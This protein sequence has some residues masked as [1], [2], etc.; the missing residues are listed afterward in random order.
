MTFLAAYQ[1]LVISEPDS[2]INPSLKEA[3]LALRVATETGVSQLIQ[4][5]EEQG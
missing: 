3:F 2:A 1:S 5:E 4:G